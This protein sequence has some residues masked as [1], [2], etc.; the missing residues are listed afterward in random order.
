MVRKLLPL[1]LLALALTGCMTEEQRLV[2][3][4]KGTVEVS[5]SLKKMPFGGQAM[6]LSNLIDPQLDLKPDK[7]FSLHMSFAP[8][9]GTWRLEDKEIILTPTTVAGMSTG[10]VKEKAEGAMEKATGRMGFPLPFGGIPGTKEMRAKIEK[11]GERITLDPGQGTMV[12]GFGKMT[13]K[14]V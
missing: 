6:G 14:K 3:K 8:I 9:Q 12:G 4:W 2:G 13:F 7:T 1:L 5:D 11:D 10:E